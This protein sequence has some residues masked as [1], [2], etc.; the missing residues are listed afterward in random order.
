VTRRQK[1]ERPIVVSMSDLAASG[2]YY[3]ATPAQ[4]I[5]A[6]PGTL[7]GSIGIFGG[8]IVTGGTYRKLGMNVESVSAGRNA[9]MDSP[10]RPFSE[11]ER[12]KLQEQ[13]RAF[14]DQ[15]LQKVATSRGMSTAQVD[16]VAQGRVWTGRQAKDVGL[17]DELGGFETALQIAKRLAH[18]AEDADVELVS[19]AARG[20]LLD[21]LIERLG[22]SGRTWLASLAPE[23]IAMFPPAAF[24]TTIFRRREALAL[25]PLPFFR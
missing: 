16:A 12:A 10:V 4:A 5:V 18:I 6:Q 7:T 13:L 14:Y 11:S 15:F 20:G 1:P 22:T 8:K 17:V 25:A 21:V 23:L 2:G 9:E 19:Y 24:P 3:I